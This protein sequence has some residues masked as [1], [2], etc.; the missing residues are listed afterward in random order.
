MSKNVP[1]P[2]PRGRAA[3]LVLGLIPWMACGGCGKS[4]GP[5]KVRVVGTVVHAGTPLPSG[6]VLFASAGNR[7]GGSAVINPGG[8]FTVALDPGDYS[9]AVRCFDGH[10]QLDENGN[11]IPAKSL[12]PD[13][14]TDARTSGL[15]V[16]VTPGIKPIGFALDP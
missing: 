9:V 3:L 4:L 14:Y 2:A 16:T 6:R 11:F 7:G 1:M 13:R 8:R 5:G 12:T 15:S 10:D